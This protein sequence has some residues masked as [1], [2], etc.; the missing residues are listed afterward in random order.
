MNATRLLLLL[1]VVLNIALAIALVSHLNLHKTTHAASSAALVVVRPGTIEPRLNE[2]EPPKIVVGG[3]NSSDA[4][5]ASS[6]VSPVRVADDEPTPYRDEEKRFGSSQ[7]PAFKKHQ[8]EMKQTLNQADSG[9]FTKPNIM[10]QTPPALK[11]TPGRSTPFSTPHWDQNPA[12][13]HGER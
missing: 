4:N 5:R 10:W 3:Y 1:S 7:A 11:L 12:L 9:E 2:N 6:V 8:D 13:R